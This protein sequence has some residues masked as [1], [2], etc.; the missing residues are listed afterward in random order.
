MG[1]GECT[2]GLV[3]KT[4]SSGLKITKEKNVA[5]LKDFTAGLKQKKG[6]EMGRSKSLK[7]QRMAWRKQR[8]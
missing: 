8:R 7:R 3:E 2:T 5:L 4:E 6:K 1:V